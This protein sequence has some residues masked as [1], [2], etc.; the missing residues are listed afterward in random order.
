MK[1][2]KWVIIPTLFVSLDETRMGEQDSAQLYKLTE[3]QWE[4]FFTCWR[5]N[6]DFYRND[7]SF[8]RKFNLGVPIYYY[9]VGRRLFGKQMK[10]PLL[11]LGHVPERFLR[12]HLYLDLSKDSPLKVPA[13]V[14][15]PQM[16]ARPAI[17]AEV[18]LV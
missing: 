6:L 11:R 2:A 12:K 4:F 7:P 1:G 15:I 13:S 5:Y 8:Q 14:E 17:P 18:E 16:K 9:T 10:Y 3:L